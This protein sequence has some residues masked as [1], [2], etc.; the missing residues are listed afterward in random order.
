LKYLIISLSIF[1]FTTAFAGPIFPSR[2]FIFAPR[3]R[4]TK[5]TVKGVKFLREQGIWGDLSRGFGSEGERYAW[6]I[7]TGGLIQFAEWDNSYLSLVG[8]FEVL[9]DIYNDISFNPRAIF[10]TE[11]L[12]YGLR[13]D[14][15]EL[16]VG[17]IHRCKH[18]IDN[19]DNNTV[20][21][22][23]QRTLIYGS[24][25]AKVIWRDIHIPNYRPSLLFDSSFRRLDL[26]AQTD[27]YLIRQDSR[28]PTGA[29][30]VGT[31]LDHIN[32]SIA[33]GAKC[34]VFRT[35]NINWY[36]RASLAQ[37][38]YNSF[39]KFTTDTRIELG[40]EF[41]GDATIMNIFLGFESLK[42]DLNRP[43]PV[44]SWYQYI[45]F[46]FIGKNVGL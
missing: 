34:D 19:L 33:F 27:A 44:N 29:E 1:L 23:E 20:G 15:T 38:A 25:S 43:Y 21:A 24:L 41:S 46:R 35:W 22:G 11:G 31:D 40:P 18:D 6:S 16:N 37:A 9:S 26:W 28:L 32:F 30:N 2:S 13:V 36:L 5:D 4:D 42:D 17:Y 10:W 14:K 45:G 3:F 12:V 7:S 39:Q 8:D